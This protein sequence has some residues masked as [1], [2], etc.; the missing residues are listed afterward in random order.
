[1][2][3][4]YQ[5]FLPP[6]HPPPLSPCVSSP[7][8]SSSNGAGARDCRDAFGVGRHQPTGV[9]ARWEP[10]ALPREH[11]L[12]GGAPPAPMGASSEAG[13]RQLSPQTSTPSL[14]RPVAARLHG[15]VIAGPHMPPA[16]SVTISSLPQMHLSLSFLDST[17]GAP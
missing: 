9:A 15:E 2:G 7:S 1:M 11:S 10:S 8:L 6:F 13:R 5:R 4:T 3:P 12:R 16:Q 14:R 17:K